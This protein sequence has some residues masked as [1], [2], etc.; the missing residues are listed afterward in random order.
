MVAHA[1]AWQAVIISVK[2]VMFYYV[3]ACF[4]VCLCVCL[5]PPSHKNHWP[6][7]HENFYK[8]TI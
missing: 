4:S 6:Y 7:L 8:K 5:L 3:F 1:Y 2:E